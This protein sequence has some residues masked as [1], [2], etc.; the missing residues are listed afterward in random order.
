ML[1]EKTSAFVSFAYFCLK[2]LALLLFMNFL[3][4]SA[5][6]CGDHILLSR[7]QI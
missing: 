7:S 1:S 5:V 3:A 6:E 2:T 4:D